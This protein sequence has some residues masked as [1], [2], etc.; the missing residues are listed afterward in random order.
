MSYPLACA[1]KVLRVQTA[2]GPAGPGVTQVRIWPCDPS[3]LQIFWGTI[4]NPFESETL[5]DL[6]LIEATSIDMLQDVEIAK[7][8]V[9]DPSGGTLLVNDADVLQ[10]DAASSRWVNAQFSVDAIVSPPTYV[11]PSTGATLPTTGMVM[12]SDGAGGTTWVVPPG[13]YTYGSGA[14]GTYTYSAGTV[15]PGTIQQF[16]MSQLPQGWL[17]C[18]GTA[19]SRS[20]YQRLFAAIGTNWGV[21]DGTTT[22]NVPAIAAVPIGAVSNLHHGIHY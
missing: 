22:F 12:T 10:Y 2:R 4:D 18:D 5:V 14:F 20:L 9:A 15:P 13:G 3:K 11:D 19:Y 17:A 16:A 8:L 7:D 6:L 21:G 1:A